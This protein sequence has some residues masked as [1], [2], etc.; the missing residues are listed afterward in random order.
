MVSA[1]D[2][3]LCLGHFGR[4]QVESLDHQLQ[5]FVS[6]PL[7]ERQNVSGKRYATREIG[8]LGAPR[9]NAMRTQVNVV[10]AILVVQ[11]LAISGHQHRD[12]I[13]EQQSAR[14]DRPR[15]AVNHLMSNSDILQFHGVHQVMQRYVGVTATQA[16]KQWSHE[17]G[18]RNERVAAE[19][20]EQKVEPN[21]VRLQTMQCL[22]Q[23]VRACWIVERPAAHDIKALQFDV[24]GRKFVCQN[25][26]VE[27]WI[28]LQLLSEMKSIFTEPPG[29][30]GKSRHQANL[31]SSPAFER[32][33]FDVLSAEDVADGGKK[34]TDSDDRNCCFTGVRHDIALAR[35]PSQRGPAG[36]ASKPNP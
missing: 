4:D 16:G 9:E 8:K 14:S 7:A 10:A 15:H 35:R 25:G 34:E 2:H 18:E 6:S 11:N 30:G 31:H 13:R 22:E 33:G 28:A 32:S 29:T 19:R 27:K 21:Y 36:S 26:K 24:I 1:G 20:A 23:A 5:P 3:E 12:R 17:A